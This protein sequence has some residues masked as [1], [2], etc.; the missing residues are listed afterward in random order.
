MKVSRKRGQ[1]ISP[2]SCSEIIVSLWREFGSPAVGASELTR[3]HDAL[4]EIFGRDEVPSP[5]RIA[6]KL[7]Q[8]GAALRHPEIIESDARWREAQ[9][10]NRMNAF[11]SL[12][13]LQTGVPLQL[14]QAAAIIA[15][16]E[17]QRGRFLNTSD[18]VALAEV[19][20]LGREARE[21][22]KNRSMDSLRSAADREVQA[23]ISEWFRVWLETPNLFNQWLELR[24]SSEAFKEKFS[25][26]D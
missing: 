19:K 26:S 20:T 24:R 4:A 8:E 10:A 3:L 9:I 2:G 13:L 7:A 15:E 6:R 5:A 18:E 23:E 17:E 21:V 16:L 22:A 11:Q 12:R 14:N 1:H 25:D